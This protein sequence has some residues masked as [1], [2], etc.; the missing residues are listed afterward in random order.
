MT[1]LDCADSSISTPK[2]NETLT[3]L[4]ALSLLNNPFTLVMA[5]K[6]ATN[7]LDS[8]DSDPE[9]LVTQAFQRVTG[10]NPKDG[11]LQMMLHYLS[12]HG[13]PNLCR[14]LFNLSELSFID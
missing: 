3:A 4:Q 1:T 13:L 7:L 14:S 12:Q 8:G 11:E 10:R 2:R 5:D 9:F 6:F